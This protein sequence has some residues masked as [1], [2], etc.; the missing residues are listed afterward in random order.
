MFGPITEATFSSIADRGHRVWLV[1]AACRAHLADGPEPPCI[2]VITDA[3]EAIQRETEAALLSLYPDARVLCYPMAGSLE[4]ALRRR[5]LTLEAV[6]VAP[7]GDVVDPFAGQADHAAGELRTI[8]APDRIFREDPISLLRVA[9]SLAWVDHVPSGELKRFS[10][11][12]AGN[13]LDCRKRKAEWA[14]IMN[15]LLMGPRIEPALQWMYDTRLL[16]FCMP[17]VTAMVGFHTSCRVHHK[18]IWDHTK[19]VTQKAAPNLVVRWAALCHDIGKIWTRRVNKQGKVHFFRHEEH[20]AMLFES[21]GYRFGLSED[22]IERVSYVIEQ[23]SRVNLYEEEWSDSAVRRLIRDTEG[24][25]KELVLFS[26]ADFTTKHKGR[27]AAIHKSLAELTG[28][29]EEVRTLD[30]KVPALP[31]G[32]GNAVIQRFGLRPSRLLGDLMKR[33]ESQ[34]EAKNLPGQAPADVYLTWLA[35]DAQSQADMAGQ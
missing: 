10:S 26:R 13:I 18:D 27:I 19:I 35:D 15:N 7:T 3:P 20:G 33:L 25:L 24:R 6:A 17:E 9:A 31:K 12:D 4:D 2:E 8:E 22:L 32:L 28:R 5:I 29:I 14:P 1:G 16:G 21:I 30:A 11:R 34:V 23:H